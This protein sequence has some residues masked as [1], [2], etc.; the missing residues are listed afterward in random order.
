VHTISFVPDSKIA[1]D[2]SLEGLPKH[3]RLRTYLV[4]EL[5]AGRLRPGDA[6]PTEHELAER[7]NMSRNTVRQALGQLE[8]NGMIRR[9]RGRGTFI[10]EAAMERLKSGL[11]IFALV[12]PETRQGYYPSLQRGF[13][14]ASAIHHNQV[15]VCDT[16]NDPFRQAD[17]L[18]QLMDKKVAGIAL[19][20]TTRPTTPAH[21]IR[22]LRERGI[23]VVFCH[24]G[25]EG[26]QAPLVAFSALDVGRVAGTA[27]LAQGHRRVAFVGTQKA[28][29]GSQYEQGLREALQKGGAKLPAELVCYDD[30]TKIDAAHERFLAGHL[31][32]LLQTHERPTAIFCT[33][34]SQ[35]EMVYLLLH[36]MGVRV[37]EE[38]SLVGFGG[39]WREGA[40]TR[41]LTSV[42]VDEEEL[43]RKT[44]TLLDELRRRERPLDDVTEILMP[45]SLTEGETLGAAPRAVQAKGSR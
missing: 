40:I 36:R 22:P 20:P 9:V 15:I 30:T 27:M 19:V 23:P 16:D 42:A 44:V 24:R 5:Q 10:H 13:H 41:R 11:D 2:V 34:D 12:I 31:E 39:T 4:K 25:V 1:N 37:P 6:L 14:E 7:A 35:A 17:A 29:L 43:G 18:L 21:Q 38:I 33:F 8:R 32:G 26:I 3:E 28:G 45:L